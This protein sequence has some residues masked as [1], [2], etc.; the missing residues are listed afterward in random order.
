MQDIGVV[1]QDSTVRIMFV[2]RNGSGAAVAP[3][4]AFE[5]ADIE[6]YKDGSAIQ[7]ASDVGITMT[8]PF[9][10]VT[11]LHLVAIDLSDNTDPGFWAAGSNYHVTI[12][13]DETVDSQTVVEVLA[14]FTI[15]TDSQKALRTLNTYA[16]VSDVLGT[17]TG[18]SDG[19]N[20]NL[21]AQVDAQVP[22]DVL[23][24]TVWMIR[25]A[26]DG[27]TE[28]FVV[29]DYVSTGTLATVA[30]L[31]DGANLSFT[32]AAG[33]LCWRVGVV[34]RAYTASAAALATVD[35]NVDTLVSPYITGS[36]TGGIPGT[37]ASGDTDLTG[38][39]DDELIGR[40]I[41]FTGGTASGQAARIRD[42]TSTGGRVSYTTIITA[43]AVSD[44][45]V[46]V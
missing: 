39:L 11:G 33:D 40:T 41:V 13:P 9:D 42:Y 27:R 10:T 31:G 45:F 29:T 16:Y 38:Y 19:S 37:S 12:Q 15:E 18:V 6:I 24:G 20:V 26:T 35:A 4:T 17:Q 8:S 22:D 14:Q 43:P 36:V 28:E 1:Q 30:R 5:N 34:D 32:P 7:R 3:S 21:S 23:I 44:T 46:I 25:D 2:T